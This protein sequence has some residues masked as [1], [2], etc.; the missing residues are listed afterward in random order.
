MKKHYKI[1]DFADES[2][3]NENSYMGGETKTKGSTKS[4]VTTVMNYTPFERN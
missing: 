3:S 2:G 1:P 4:K